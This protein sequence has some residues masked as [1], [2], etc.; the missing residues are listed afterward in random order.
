MED[1]KDI[2][3]VR[4]IINWPWTITINEGNFK[5]SSLA[6]WPPHLNQS[7]TES[8]LSSAFDAWAAYSGLKFVSIGDPSKADI[9]VAFARY[10]HGDG[11]AFDGPGFVLAHAFYPYGETHTHT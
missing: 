9:V 7:H 8:L 10:S 3:P 1:E 5:S 4:T 6:N 11:Y 2:L